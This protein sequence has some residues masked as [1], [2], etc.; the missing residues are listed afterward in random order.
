MHYQ[1]SAGQSRAS[2]GS[3]ATH[4]ECKRVHV[5]RWSH[6]QPRL[7]FWTSPDDVAHRSVPPEMRSLWDFECAVEIAQ[8]RIL[9]RRSTLVVDSPV[10]QD[11]VWLEICMKRV[12]SDCSRRKIQVAKDST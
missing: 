6:A 5:G 3:K 8:S 9:H 7:C 1:P 10:D 11:V 12:V 2:A 4:H